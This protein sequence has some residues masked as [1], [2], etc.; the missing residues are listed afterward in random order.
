MIVNVVV[1]SVAPVQVIVPDALYAQVYFAR[2]EQ[3]VPGVQGPA[4]ATG[5]A[6]FP[7]ATAFTPTWSGTGLAYSGGVTGD[8]T[9]FGSQVFV[10]LNVLFTG[11]S[12]FGTGQYSI[13]LPFT[14]AKHQDVFAGSVHDAGSPIVHWSLK[15]H[16]DAGS[17]VM[18]LWYLSA[19]GNKLRDASFQYNDPFTLT[20]SDQ[21]H[22]S[23]N[24]EKTA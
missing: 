8:H 13:T 24:Y 10:N 1:P 9:V 20:T 17:N 4:G 15:G 2:G 14:A 23:F 11:V 7:T 18:T 6:V 5:G 22:L 21:F 19:Q 12:N 16:L 3:G